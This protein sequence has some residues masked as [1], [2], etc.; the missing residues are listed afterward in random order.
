MPRRFLH[1]HQPKSPAA[2]WVKA[3]FGS[4][5]AIAAVGLL[6]DLTAMPLLLAP[7]GAS[8]VLLFALPDSPLSQPAHVIGGHALAAVLSLALAAVLP[9]TWWAAALAVGVVIAATSALRV[10]HPPAGADPLV[11]FLGAPAADLFLGSVLLGS[12]TLVALA[13]LVHRLPPRTNSYPLP[14]ASG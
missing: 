14:P 1:R 13:M 6:G 3:G 10:T 7:F 9:H 11:V 5:L 8:S 12:V 2:L 4:A